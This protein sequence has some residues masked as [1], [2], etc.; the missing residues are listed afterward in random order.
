MRV[1][2]E[3]AFAGSGFSAACDW[4]LQVQRSRLPPVPL[5]VELARRTLRDCYPAHLRSI[6]SASRLRHRCPRTSSKWRIVDGHVS[7]LASPQVCV[8]C[9]FPARGLRLLQLGPRVR[10]VAAAAAG[11]CAEK[12]H[13]FEGR[14]RPRAPYASVGRAGPSECRCG[15]GARRRIACSVLAPSR[16]QRAVP[17]H[18]GQCAGPARLQLVERHPDHRQ[19]PASNLGSDLQCVHV[20]RLGVA[21]HL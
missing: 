15:F 7:L 19:Q 3:G 12:I 4:A 13:Q 1:D 11:A 10:R 18:D 14:R 16:G 9:S 5:G 6:W 8:V 20:R 21:A 17:A 2:L